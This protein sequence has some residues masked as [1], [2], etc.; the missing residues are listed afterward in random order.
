MT[1]RLDT[2][3]L[4]GGPRSGATDPVGTLRPS[5]VRGLMHTWVRAVFGPLLAGKAPLL[6]AAEGLLLG[7]STDIEVRPPRQGEKKDSIRSQATFRLSVTANGRA[8][9][10][11]TV[12][13]RGFPNRPGNDRK[14]FREGHAAGQTQTLI[15]QPR[16]AAVRGDPELPAM[17]WAIVWLSFTLGAIGTRSRRGYGSLTVAKV[18]RPPDMG[19]LGVAEALPMFPEEPSVDTLRQ[20]IP[21]GV[22]AVLTCA[23]GWL[24]HHEFA[25]AASPGRPRHFALGSVTQVSVGDSQSAFPTSEAAMSRLMDVCSANMPRHA[26]TTAR[27]VLGSPEPR[28]PRPCGCVCTRSGGAMYP[29]P[30]LEASRLLRK[31]GGSAAR[32]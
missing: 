11:L 14:G 13:P 26:G 1:L 29:W 10:R 9:A 2:P 12:A 20:S 7:T 8:P 4:Q 28:L 32:C 3:L 17:L 30:R 16:P 5:S 24:R 31:R 18:D 22:E 21:Q 6:R 15:L 25:V 19:G 23:R 27:A